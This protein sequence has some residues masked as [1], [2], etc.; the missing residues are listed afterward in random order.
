MKRR[1]RTDGRIAAYRTVDAT[2]E[3]EAIEVAT[4]QLLRSGTLRDPMDGA[5]ALNPLT[6]YWDVRV[7]VRP[8]PWE[9]PA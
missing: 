7:Y 3:A 9:V 1:R 6:G 8:I 4:G 5:A 2:T